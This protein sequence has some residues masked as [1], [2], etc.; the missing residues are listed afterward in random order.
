MYAHPSQLRAANRRRAFRLLLTHGS[1]SRADL[2]RATGLSAM[3]AGKVVDDLIGEGLIEEKESPLEA[4]P[5]VVMGRP[6]RNLALASTLEFPLVELGVRQTSVMVQPLDFGQPAR[7]VEFATPRTVATLLHRIDAAREKLESPRTEFVMV[8]VPGILD[9]R[10]DRVLCSPNLP[11]IEEHRFLPRLGDLFGAKVCAAQEIQALALGHQAAGS[12][13]ESFVL[14][15]FGD[16]VGGSLVAGG[17]LF[18][19]TLPMAGELGHTGVHG[20]H[21]ACACGSVGCVETLVSREGL[22]SSFKEGKGS[23][24][25]SWDVLKEHVAAKGV[26][27]WLARAIDAA[28][29]VIAGAINLVGTQDVV[30]TG[31]LPDLHAEIGPLFEQRIRMHSLIGRIGRLT[32][33]VAVRRRA[34]GLVAAAADR[35]LLAE[36]EMVEPETPSAPAAAPA[37]TPRR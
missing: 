36:P 6:P 26:E 14:V 23:H 16:G 34:L 11:L 1:M 8:S 37:R 7:R 3:T 12:A 4:T 25:A 21:R 32:C 13:P 29:V 10:S 9:A 19:G 28:A 22:L 33:R 17:Q 35:F 15:D 31:D 2:A 27:P 24:A 20:N 18:Q 5:R 30:L